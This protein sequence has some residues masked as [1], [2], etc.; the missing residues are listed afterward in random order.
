MRTKV[1][2]AH[3]IGKADPFVPPHLLKVG[4]SEDIRLLGQQLHLCNCMSPALIR[5]KC[6][7]LYTPIACR[8]PWE[9]EPAETESPVNSVFFP[10][11]QR[12]DKGEGPESIAYCNSCWRGYPDEYRGDYIKCY[13]CPGLSAAKSEHKTCKM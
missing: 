12:F 1:L 6:V 13:H 3:R 7:L 4:S 9:S 2:I 8:L 11:F 10:F 5:M